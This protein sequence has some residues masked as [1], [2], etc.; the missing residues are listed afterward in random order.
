MLIILLLRLGIFLRN[1]PFLDGLFHR[2]VPDGFSAPDSR[3]SRT[4]VNKKQMQMPTHEVF[5]IIYQ[6]KGVYMRCLRN[7]MPRKRDTALPGTL[8]RRYLPM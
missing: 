1:I 4:L 2:G 8:G 6:P 5:S 3:A 7:V